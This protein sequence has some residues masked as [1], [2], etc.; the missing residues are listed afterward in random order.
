MDR[1]ARDWRDARGCRVVPRKGDVDRNCISPAR[2][3]GRCVVPRKGDVDRNIMNNGELIMNIM[4]SPARGTW[5]E[6]GVPLGVER[7]RQVVPRKG[8]VDRNAAAA[9]LAWAVEK[10]VPRKGDVDRNFA[11]CAEQKCKN[12]SSPARGT[13]I[14]IQNRCIS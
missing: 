12:R 4:S 13:W 11:F 14:E 5:I 6:I 2:T 10:V 8:D 3:K 7:A 9:L 1:N